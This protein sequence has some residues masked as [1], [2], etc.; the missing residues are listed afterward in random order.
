MAKTFRLGAAA[1]INANT[2]VRGILTNPL[3]VTLTVRAPDGTETASTL[4]SGTVIQAET[5]KFYVDVTLDQSGQWV[6]RWETTG[7]VTGADDG[8]LL[9]ARS[10]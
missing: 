1:R 7:D 2:V 5:G 10:V 8:E 4:E 3:T 9:V 6:W